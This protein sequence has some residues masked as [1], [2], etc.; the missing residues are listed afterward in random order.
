M[1]NTAG[2]MSGISHGRP[3][4]LRADLEEN[5]TKIDFFGEAVQ[6]FQQHLDWVEKEGRSASPEWQLSRGL[7]RLAQGLQEDRDEL[8]DRARSF[9]RSYRASK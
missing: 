3:N 4:G 5:A 6:S 9:A 1:P 2:L 8:Q 7:L